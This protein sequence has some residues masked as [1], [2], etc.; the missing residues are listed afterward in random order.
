MQNLSSPHMYP[1]RIPPHSGEGRV[2]NIAM[3]YKVR[4]TRCKHCRNSAP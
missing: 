3:N 4:V 1:C 2:N